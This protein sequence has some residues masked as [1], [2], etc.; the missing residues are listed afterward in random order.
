[1]FYTLRIPRFAMI[2]IWLAFFKQGGQQAKQPD[3]LSQLFD[4]AA[5]AFQLEGM[6]VPQKLYEKRGVRG[7]RI[8]G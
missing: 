4:K 6:A 5:N 2:A 7:S 1:M 8:S 3:I